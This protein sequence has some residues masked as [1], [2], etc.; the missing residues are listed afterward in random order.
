LTSL[1]TGRGA[2]ADGTARKAGV[3]SMNSEPVRPLVLPL[4]DVSATLR[5]VG[6]KG[7][8]L[9]RMVRASLPVPPGFLIT[10]DAYRA[11][12]E[13]DGLQASIVKLAKDG[14]QSSED[15]SKQIRDLF[16]RAEIPEAVLDEIQR[17]YGGLRQVGGDISPLAVRS[18]ATA[19][20]L[21]GASFAGQHDSFLN[22]RGEQA[23]IDAVKRCWSSLWTARALEYRARQGIEP[24]GVWMA[25]IVQQT[26]AAESSGVL[27]TANPLTGARD[28]IVL[29]AS[30]GL[31][32]AIVSGAVTPDHI[33]ADKT[34]DA[35]KAIKIGDK[36]VMTA[37]TDTG[38]VESPVE[39]G[40]RRAQVLSPGQ[41]TELVI[42][43]RAI[44]A[45]YGAPQDIE[46]CLA[47]ATFYIVQ[48]RP[49]TALPPAPVPWPSPIP[50]AKWMKD[51]Q[52]AEWA[53]EPPSPL[54]ATTTFATMS[55]A[56]E[57]ARSFPPVPKHHA[58]WSTLINGWLYQRA[59]H[60]VISLLGFM[61]G[62]YIC[63]VFKP[64]NG[65]ARV[66]RSW[67][68][69]ISAL[70][71]LEQT[72]LEAQSDG[73]LRAHSVRALDA[74]SW[75]WVEVIW[76]AAI[77]RQSA[78]MLDSLDLR[79]LTN[80]GALFRGNESLLLDSERALR[81]AARDPAAVEDY[82][83]RFGHTVE[84]A[85]PIHPTLRES[86]EHLKVQLAAASRTDVGP[87]E[88]LAKT[89]KDR[90]AAEQAV[91]QLKGL[92]AGLARRMIFTGQTHAANTDNAVFH[93]QR[94]LAAVR[95]TFLEAG[96]R[97]V[98]A[99][100]LEQAE[101]VFFLER[102]EVWSGTDAFKSTVIVRRVFR[103][104][105]KRLAPPPFVPPASDPVW[106]E[107][108][109]IKAMPTAQR[110]AMFGRGERDRDGKRVLV[111]SPS[112]PG[113][114]Q[115]IARVISGPRDFVR[116]NPGDVLVA[117]A[118]S[119]IWTPLL[120][121]AAAAVTEVGGPFAHAAIVAREFGIPL[122]DGA[123]DAT[124]VITDGATIMVDGTAGIVEL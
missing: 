85:D 7:A 30:W 10:T 20:D 48:A 118:T 25:V 52:T 4:D 5:R 50:G 117:Q 119:P 69:R 17:A 34:T 92:R 100:Y 97:L 62:M 109:L 80:S 16:Q 76:F 116:F 68:D 46:W 91:R 113:R 41:V 42:L 12:V 87:D 101:D 99:G 110:S 71:E 88:R 112:S 32:E 26:V 77:G 70:A 33:V 73:Q 122:V 58:P 38:T 61:L 40:K 67:P 105:H 35:I 90:Q 121:I 123:T 108:P 57:L 1:D 124:R 28:E 3:V 14:A 63:L 37:L 31:G 51:V 107:D 104:Q 13:T 53:K 95:A 55:A 43:G 49:I 39:E 22:V 9:A 115:G 8:S 79:E 89:Q 11:F 47:K 74:L 59:D 81:K 21:P 78:Q 18:T 84:S 6:G 15:L 2:F 102:D 103:D 19:E 96:R 106:V 111:G 27:F 44:E 120:G 36:A 94:V 60:K 29:D 114:A 98:R 64:L 24:S 82:L 65:H 56:R 54:G 86:P 23:L 75:W 93:F 83:A 72:D 45:L 66:M